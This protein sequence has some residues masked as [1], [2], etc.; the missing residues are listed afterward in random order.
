MEGR[1]AGTPSK[2]TRNV[3]CPGC[4]RRFAT[5]SALKDHS[6]ALH[7]HASSPPP[8]LRLLLPL[9][10]GARSSLTQ[11]NGIQA[12][13]DQFGALSISTAEPG[14]TRDESSFPDQEKQSRFGWTVLK[15]DELPDD[16]GHMV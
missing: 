8:P 1:S 4:S 12:L 16:M 2:P 7:R 3:A 10:N 11:Q 14:P 15:D 5:Q 6:Q 13:H 9:T